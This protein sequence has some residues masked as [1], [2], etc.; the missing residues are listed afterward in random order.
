MN[1]LDHIEAMTG[2]W[3]SLPIIYEG[4][5]K[6][7][8]QLT[9]DLYL[10]SLK[11]TLFS[12]TANRSAEV[13]GTEKLRLRISRILWEVLKRANFE[14]SVVSVHDDYYVSRI[15]DAPPIEVIVKAAFVGTPKHLYSG[16]A[17]YPTRKG[18]PFSIHGAHDPYVRFDWR[19]PL[20]G[21]DEC[22]PEALADYFIDV[23][24]A[25]QTALSAFQVLRAFLSKYGIQLLDICFFIDSSGK[26]IFGELSPDCMR[27]KLQG[28]DVD[29]DLWRKGRSD[30]ELLSRWETF[31]QRVEQ[32]DAR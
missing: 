19:N 18:T 10:I 16:M 30:A 1:N 14:M 8:R 3:Q 4:E 29:K 20:P 11:P 23:T 26:C 25:T 5:S 22:L 28:Q 12:Y 13:P 17:D 6:V 7:L 27:A 31:A 21:K 32:D 9:A 2:T 15:V 24:E